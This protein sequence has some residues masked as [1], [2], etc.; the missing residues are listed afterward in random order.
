MFKNRISIITLLLF[1]VATITFGGKPGPWPKTFT[2][3]YCWGVGWPSYNA[4]PQEPL[5]L[6]QNGTWT[7]SGGT[8]TW[9]FGRGGKT[10]TLNVDGNTTRYDG[11]L[12]PGGFY[13]GTMTTGV[14]GGPT[15]TWIGTF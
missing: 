8:G 15:G 9:L 4:C 7:A 5:S 2:V 14:P 12:Q 3:N 6:N 1:A 11:V 10:M 13:E